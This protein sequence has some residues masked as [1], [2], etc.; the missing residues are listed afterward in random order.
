MK[1]ASIRMIYAATMMLLTGMTGMAQMVG[2][3]AAGTAS[4]TES[5]K[6]TGFFVKAGA[7][8]PVSEFKIIP[9]FDNTTPSEWDEM[10][11]SSGNMG[12]KTGFYI[13]AGI[14]LNLMNSS[15]QDNLFG[16][17]YYPIIAAFWQTSLDWSETG[18]IF[19]EKSIYT[20]PFRILDIGQRYGLM[21]NPV[22]DL[23]FGLYYR[24][25][26]IIPFDFETV[27]E[28][29]FL[30]TGS[31]TTSD[32]APVFMM[33]HSGGI[34]VSYSILSLSAELYFARPTMDVTYAYTGMGVASTTFTGKIPVRLLNLSLAVTF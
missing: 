18:D 10:P 6:F 25:G 29:D 28:S 26:L 27:S 15:D 9:E 14:A 32:D 33:S 11:V 8:I 16:F 13:E 22:K 5:A 24:P 20:K 21:I 2:G 31:M 1:R 4:S 17:Y 34:S 12:A 23:S 7:A 30:L 3:G 19:T